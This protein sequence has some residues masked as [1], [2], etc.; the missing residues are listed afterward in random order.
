MAD[1]PL[2]EKDMR[3]I[4]R[5]G[6]RPGSDD[7]LTTEQFKA[8]FDEGIIALAKYL[9]EVVVPKINS[10]QGGKRADDLDMNGFQLA[11]LRD[12]QYP[13]EAATKRYV[14]DKHQIYKAT[15]DTEWAGSSAPYTQSVYIPGIQKADTPHIAPILDS[16]YQTALQQMDSWLSISSATAGDNEIQFTCLEDKPAA[17]IPIQIEVNR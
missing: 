7:G 5:L 15:I 14:D 8:K 3:I 2:F 1:I 9:N 6:D 12:P 13:D 10:D 11:N 16:A 4:S 17:K